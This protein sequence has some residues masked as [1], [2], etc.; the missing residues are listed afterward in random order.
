MRARLLIL[1][2]VAS[3]SMWA[4]ST[5]T[6]PIDATSIE[7]CRAGTT[8]VVSGELRLHQGAPAWAALVVA[9]NQCAKL[10]LPDDFY[11][12]AKQWNGSV[13]KVTGQA[14]EQPDFDQSTGLIMLWY[15]ERDRKLSLGMCDGGVG[16][17]VDSMRSRSGRAW[18]SKGTGSVS[19][20][21][22]K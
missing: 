17:Y 10:A 9:G 21:V 4:C 12:A 8:C 18:P 2:L 15:T 11:A 19:L 1:V 22:R 20:P 6:L 16:I 3:C 7:A 13:V 5:L 14:F